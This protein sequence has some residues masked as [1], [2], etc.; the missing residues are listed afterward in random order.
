MTEWYECMFWGGV[1]V[2]LMVCFVFVSAYAAS[3]LDDLKK[4][5]GEMRHD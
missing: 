5:L 4:V 1:I 3:G 2:F